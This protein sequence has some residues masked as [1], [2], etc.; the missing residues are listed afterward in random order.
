MSGWKFAGI[1]LAAVLLQF[2]IVSSIQPA[3]IRPDL[4]LLS[5]VAVAM[6]E[7]RRNWVLT[8]GVFAGTTLDLTQG[9]F[10]GLNILLM[11]AVAWAVYQ[12][13]QAFMRTSPGLS[14]L[15]VFA[16]SFPVQLGRAAAVSVAGGSYGGWSPVL[17]FLLISA[18][19]NGL[20]MIAV[21]GAI[22][23]LR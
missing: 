4:I 12:V 16:L 19:V 21:H 22:Q 10:I 9:R 17:W 13:A 14:A 11:T 8:Y 18:A 5:T 3:E 1:P 2:T 7:K 20:V 23:V 15:T 6:L